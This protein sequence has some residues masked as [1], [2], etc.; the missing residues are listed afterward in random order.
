MDS[1]DNSSNELEKMKKLLV[2]LVTL[3]AMIIGTALP[4]AQPVYAA[5]TTLTVSGEGSAAIPFYC[6]G[7]YLPAGDFTNL[8]S[9]DDGTSYWRI[10]SA[11]NLRHV[12]AVDNPGLPAGSV[13]NSVKL[14]VKAGDTGTPRGYYMNYWDGTNIYASTVKYTGGGSY[15]LS[16]YTWA[17]NPGTGV[18]WTEAEV[19]SAQF[20]VN[21]SF[22][23]ALFTWLYVVVTYTPTSLPE[24]SSSDA[25][26]IG[27]TTATLNGEI[28]D[29]GLLDIDYY[30]FVWDTSDKGDPGNLDPSA[31]PGTWTNGWKS[32]LGDYGESSREHDTTA[33]TEG[34]TYYFRF[35]AHNSLGWEYSSASSFSC[36]YDPVVSSVAATDVTISTARLQAYLDDDGDEDCEVRWGY[37]ETDEGNDIEAYDTYT[38]YDG[39][40]ASGNSPYLDIGSLTGSTEYFFNVEARN[41]CG[42]STGTSRSFTTETSVGTPSNVTAIPNADSIIL[43]WTKG[44]GASNTFI[45]YRINTCPADETDGTLVYLG[46]AST[47][48]LS[49]LASGT[50]YC[51]YL[52]GYDPVEGYSSGNVTIHA[53]TLAEGVA[54]E[55][56]IGAVD[57]P[58]GGMS[59]TPSISEELEDSIPL[60]PYVRKGSD[61]TGI[62]IGYFTY[63]LLLIVATG[64]SYFIYRHTHSIEGV[65]I[66][67][68]AMFWVAYPVLH[69]PILVPLF[70]TFVGIGY[71]IYRARSV[72]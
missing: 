6:A 63:I 54:I 27:C 36:H 13:I 65:V 3:A 55:A 46:T 57:K 5:T 35:A 22:T 15:S 33:L 51:F 56:D 49:D 70:A 64:L 25:T 14:Y 48:T 30:G 21:L 12:W 61:S 32:A 11:S 26:D 39:S 67:W 16:S 42:T 43:S 52:V 59:S 19:D 45:R 37:G 2:H 72:I 18:A 9:N 60:M 4:F 68:V 41:D 24:V 20:G 23:D 58:T 50:D 10:T 28:T 38:A 17:T 1:K 29:D 34:E 40:Y 62:P 8:D 47:T 66:I 44:T 31:P 7:S 69:I 71:G 53:T